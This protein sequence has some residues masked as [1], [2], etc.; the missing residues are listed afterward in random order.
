MDTISRVVVGLSGGVDSA[1][2]AY[3]LKKQGYQVIG[4]TLRTWQAESGA[5]SRCC[6]ISDAR[7]TAMQLDI[8]FYNVN[9]LPEFREHVTDPFVKAYLEGLTPNPCVACNRHI[10]W[11]KLLSF[12]DEINAGYVATGHYARIVRTEN[13]RYTVKEAA[14][15]EKDQTYMLYQLSQEQLART[16]M[17]LSDLTKDE[18]RAIAKEAGLDVAGKQDS[19]EICF[20]LDGG[21]AEYIEAYTDDG[22]PPPGD[23]VDEEGNV[24]GRHKGIINY[25]VGQRKGLGIALGHPAYVKR[26]DAENNRVVL[27]DEA[28]VYEDRILCRDLN[29]MSVEDIHPGEK[30]SA[31][32]KIR[33]H[34]PAAEACLE[35]VDDNTVE[36]SF[37]E[38]VKAP[39]P[40]QSAVFYDEENRVIGGGIIQP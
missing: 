31:F 32:V 25:T 17:P 30:V 24:L 39:A 13:D 26:I 34:H 3:L 10:K 21:Y 28:S 7:R 36:V 22:L 4:V 27:G 33:Y 14:Y 20:V 12:A 40:G 15:A 37:A 6:D 8:P 1:V 16:I 5:Y 18:V 2:A 35:R 11:E 19:Q 38:P 9:S 23:F 29:F